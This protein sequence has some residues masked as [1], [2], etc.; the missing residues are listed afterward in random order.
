MHYRVLDARPI[1]F[2]AGLR[3]SDPMGR[4]NGQSFEGIARPHQTRRW[5]LVAVPTADL[6]PSEF[7]LRDGVWLRDSWSTYNHAIS[8]RE[9]VLAMAGVLRSGGRLPPVL[10]ID[11]GGAQLVD[12]Y[13]RVAAARTA[14]RS[15][16]ES[17]LL[18][19]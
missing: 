14:G 6:A 11:G 16:V 8:E 1:S 18:V 4:D 13:H 3:P 19:T 12:G 9:R 10:V 17:Y 5:L 7:I 15:E 2:A